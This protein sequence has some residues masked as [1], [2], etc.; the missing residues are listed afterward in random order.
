MIDP[1][2]LFPPKYS[3]RLCFENNVL[4]FLNKYPS[5][6]NGW[7]EFLFEQVKDLL[8]S[9][10][11]LTMV[12]V[13]RYHRIDHLTTMVDEMYDCSLDSACAD[14]DE[15]NELNPNVFTDNHQLWEYL[16][17]NEFLVKDTLFQIADRM[18]LSIFHPLHQFVVEAKHFGMHFS[19]FSYAMVNNKHAVSVSCVT[20]IEVI[21]KYDPSWYD[22]LSMLAPV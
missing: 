2:K 8:I 14:M 7:Y 6:Y 22:R 11:Y 21:K 15:D 5:Y 12:N 3:Y 17:N 16:F 19:D 13:M 20:H 18:I 4:E 9:G 1:A 10:S